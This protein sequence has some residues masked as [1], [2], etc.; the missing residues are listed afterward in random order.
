MASNLFDLCKQRGLSLLELADQAALDL[1]RARAIYH[2]RWTPSPEER[3]RIANTLGTSPEE[4]SWG[5]ETPIQH[6]H[7]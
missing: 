4:I 6:I 2:G 1:P 5:H 7:D 3:R